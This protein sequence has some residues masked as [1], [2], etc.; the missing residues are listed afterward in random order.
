MDSYWGTD[1]TVIVVQM[2]SYWGYRCVCVRALIVS[3]FSG[4]SDFLPSVMVSA[5]KIK[6]K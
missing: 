2:D 3:G 1:G 5:N 4:Y 6:L